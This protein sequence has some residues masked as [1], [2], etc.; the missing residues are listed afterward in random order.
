[1]NTLICKHNAGFFSCCS[2]KLNEIIT[3]INVNKSI[4]EDID[5]K[6]LMSLYNPYW[7]WNRPFFHDITSDFFENNEDSN[8][9]WR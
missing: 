8:F 7:L 6:N 5:C 9:M 2:V 3:Y 1:M 4:P